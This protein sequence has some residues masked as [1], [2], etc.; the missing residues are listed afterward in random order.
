MYINVIVTSRFASSKIIKS[1]GL[2]KRFIFKNQNNKMRLPRASFSIECHIRASVFCKIYTAP[3]FLYFPQRGVFLKI[4]IF[5][6]IDC[7][8]AGNH[9]VFIAFRTIPSD[10]ACVA[11]AARSIDPSPL[12]RARVSTFCL[13]YVGAALT[14]ICFSVKTRAR[15]PTQRLVCI[16]AHYFIARE[17]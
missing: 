2:G 13:G 12:P 6:R 11:L 3:I 7:F 14:P 5:E 10:R 16:T 15:A 4:H 9:V 17:L 1:V 8:C